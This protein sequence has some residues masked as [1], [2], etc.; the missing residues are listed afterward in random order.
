MDATCCAASRVRR[1]DIWVVMAGIAR[2]EKTPMMIT[3]TLSSMSVKPRAR[4]PARRRA[5]RA[6]PGDTTRPFERF[7]G[8]VGAQQGPCRFAGRTNDVFPHDFVVH[9]ES[10]GGK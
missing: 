8:S 6:V 1:S 10:Q 7:T 2:V 4:T 3:T 9:S 5:E